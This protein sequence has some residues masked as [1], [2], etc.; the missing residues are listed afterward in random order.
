MS[1]IDPLRTLE[2]RAI[3]VAVVG[4]WTSFVA[5]GLILAQ[6]PA[7]DTSRATAQVTID[8]L[9]LPADASAPFLS[10]QGWVIDGRLTANPKRALLDWATRHRLCNG[11][12]DERRR[13][14]MYVSLGPKPTYGAFLR[15]AQSLREMGL[16]HNVFVKDGGHLGGSVVNA[17]D[18]GMVGLDVC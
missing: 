8:R 10:E 15:T 5:A 7:G 13:P 14:F 11:F 3:P 2:R 18:N 6:V 17:R 12:C 16:C 4:Q 9:I 1:A